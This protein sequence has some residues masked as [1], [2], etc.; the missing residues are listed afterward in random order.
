MSFWVTFVRVLGQL[1]GEGDH[2][3]F[4]WLQAGT[5][6]VFDDG[7]HLF[8]G[9]ESGSK[10]WRFPGRTSCCARRVIYATVQGANSLGVNNYG[11]RLYD[12]QRFR[13]GDSDAGV[14][15]V[16]DQAVYVIGNFNC[17]APSANSD[18]V[19]AGCGEIGKKPGAILGDT[20]NVLSCAWVDPDSTGAC[21]SSMSN[22]ADEGGLSYRP[23]DERSTTSR[24]DGKPTASE[25]FVN[26]AFLAGNDTTTCPTNPGGRDCQRDYYSGGLENYPRF[27]EM[28]PGSARFWYQGSFVAIDTPKHTC[29]TFNAGLIAIDDGTFSCRAYQLNGNWLQGYWRMQDTYGYSPP[30]RRWFYDV[31]FND[32]ASLP[33]LSPRFVTLRQRFFTEEFR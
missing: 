14:T 33:P 31:N 27:H 20:V 5:A 15:F 30:P 26:A 29:F 10:M 1:L 18:S 12:A 16:S 11:V 32:A 3:H 17:R 8:S 6:V 21:R 13:R 2:R 7:F 4:R 25:T 19:P 22:G 24:P 28:W 23:L 9:E